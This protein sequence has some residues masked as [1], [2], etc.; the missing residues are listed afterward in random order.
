MLINDASYTSLSVFPWWLKL[1][2][3][4][5]KQLNWISAKREMEC[6]NLKNTKWLKVQNQKIHT[7]SKWARQ[8]CKEGKDTERRALGQ[9]VSVKLEPT[10]T[11]GSREAAPEISP[12]QWEKRWVS[13]RRLTVVAGL[14]SFHSWPESAH[15]GV[16]SASA[17]L[18]SVTP[19]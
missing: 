2:L 14:P 17:S 7:F 13:C 5:R 1:N 6:R 18:D 11:W 9:W 16:H 8:K 3:L 10:G 4:N 19:S 15:A 12:L